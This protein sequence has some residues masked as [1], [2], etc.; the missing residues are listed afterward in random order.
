MELIEQATLRKVNSTKVPPLLAVSD[1]QFNVYLFLTPVSA[2][3]RRAEGELTHGLSSRW[4]AA[5]CCMITAVWRELRKPEEL[6]GHVIISCTFVCQKSSPPTTTMH[7]QTRTHSPLHSTPSIIH[8]FHL[9][10]CLF[11]FQNGTVFPWVRNLCFSC[12]TKR[13]KE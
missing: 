6:K 9:F 2:A 7:T 13:V 8:L 4:V 11:L 12:L 5:A 1:V 3:C 10:I